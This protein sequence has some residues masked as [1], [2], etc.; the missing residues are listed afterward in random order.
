MAIEFHC[1]HCGKGIKAPPD[2]AGKRAKC[3]ACHNSVYV[4][5]PSEELEPLN[6]API[7][8]REEQERQRALQ[9]AR[10]LQRRLL[11]DREA[12]DAGGRGVAAREAAAA[13]ESATPREDMESL[14]LKYAASMARGEL[15]TAEFLAREIRKDFKTAEEVM[16]RLTIDEVPHPAL[17]GIPR[18]VVVG[19]F[20]QL[21]ERK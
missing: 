13:R 6:L 4:P 10:E 16:Q 19:F 1:E 3:P 20:R 11:G 7:D 17:A 15:Q 9:E 12:V 5:T 18:P 8:R 14:V 21:R 2:L